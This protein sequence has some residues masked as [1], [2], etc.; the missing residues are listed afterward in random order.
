MIIPLFINPNLTYAE[1]V[2]EDSMSD[3][4]FNYAGEFDPKGFEI[5][6]KSLTKKEK[7]TTGYDK[8]VAIRVETARGIIT[9]KGETSSDV[10]TIIISY[11]KYDP[12]LG[13]LYIFRQDMK[14]Y[15][16]RYLDVS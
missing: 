5:A 2:P 11:T 6:V 10:Q 7:K 15:K 8:R 14:W 1:L 12:D 16:V 3:E 4:S 13:Y 9:F